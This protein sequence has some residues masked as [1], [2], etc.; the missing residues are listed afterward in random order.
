MIDFDGIIKH[1]T[2]PDALN[3]TEMKNIV[4]MLGNLSVIYEYTKKADENLK[5]LFDDYGMKELKDKI[6]DSLTWLEEFDYE[7]IK[8]VFK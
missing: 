6:K 7:K 5:T 3:I 2:N 8:G 4:D 1:Y